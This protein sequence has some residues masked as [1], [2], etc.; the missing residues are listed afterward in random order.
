VL[1][2]SAHFCGDRGYFTALETKIVQRV[3]IELPERAVD[4]SRLRALPEADPGSARG[5]A[6][7]WISATMISPRVSRYALVPHRES[8][9]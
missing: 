2:L 6:T 7:A 3:V 1:C 5:A 4:C 9:W 8:G